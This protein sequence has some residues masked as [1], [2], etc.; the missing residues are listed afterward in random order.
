M[1]LTVSTTKQAKSKKCT[2]WAYLLVL[3]LAKLWLSL[4]PDDDEIAAGI[5]IKLWHGKQPKPSKTTSKHNPQPTRRFPLLL[6]H[7]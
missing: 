6:R 5:T 4:P 2:R 7:S 3:A 1:I